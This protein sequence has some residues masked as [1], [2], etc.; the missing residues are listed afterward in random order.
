MSQQCALAAK[1]ANVV[2]LSPS[3]EEPTALQ[4]KFTEWQCDSAV[5]Q[6]KGRGWTCCPKGWKR[7]QKSC[8]YMSDDRM[9]WDKS[10]QNCTG[11][12]SH[13]VVINTEAEQAFLTKE[14]P[15]PLG[16]NYYIG[17]RARQVGQW[18]WVDQTPFNATAAFWRKGE[19]SN[20]A[21]EMCVI[22]HTSSEIH[23]WNDSRCEDL[24]RICEAAAVTV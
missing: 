14:L 15:G 13:L 2:P 18:Q 6:G 23:N 8:Y 1:K 11:M 21:A 19:P 16:R 9:R 20:V 12:G 10:E 24:Y 7:F 4:Q 3:D 17:L 5:P 22:I